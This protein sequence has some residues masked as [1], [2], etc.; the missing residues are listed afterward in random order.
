LPLKRRDH[1]VRHFPT[2][3]VS[4][5]GFRRQVA[6]SQVGTNGNLPSVIEIVIGTR[7]FENQYEPKNYVGVDVIRREPEPIRSV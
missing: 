7:W 5:G 4:R 3:F 2:F 1:F 6:P